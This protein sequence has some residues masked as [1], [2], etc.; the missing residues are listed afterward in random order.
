MNKP[1]L[2]F[3]WH[4]CLYGKQRSLMLVLGSLC[5]HFYVCPS[6]GYMEGQKCSHITSVSVPRVGL[7]RSLQSLNLPISTEGAQNAISTNAPPVYMDW[8]QICFS[9]KYLN[10]CLKDQLKS[11]RFGMNSKCLNFIFWV[12]Y[13]ININR[14][15][16]YNIWECVTFVSSFYLPAGYVCVYACS[17]RHTIWNTRPG[18][19]KTSHTLGTAGLRRAV[20]II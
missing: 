13:P 3:Y 20:H 1:D 9:L 12:N 18:Q 17:E 19:G 11:C 16:F 8:H 6:F 15:H 4:T 7:A 2:G 10:L 5:V 14:S